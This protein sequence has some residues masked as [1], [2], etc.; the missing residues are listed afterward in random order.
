MRRI[1]TGRPSAVPRKR[2]SPRYKLLRRLCL[3]LAALAAIVG[4][5]A[6]VWNSGRMN[7]VIDAARQWSGDL[8][9]SL[10]LTI[11]EMSV[12]GRQRTS[13]SAIQTALGIRRGT[14]ILGIDLERAKERLEALPWIATAA[15]ERKLPDT[16]QVQVVERTAVGRWR[17]R[18]RILLVDRN[19]ILFAAGKAETYTHLPLLKGGGA[20]DNAAALVDML[21]SQPALAKR[22]AQ[23][24]RRGDRRW[25]LVFESG[26]LVRLPEKKPLRAWERLAYLDRQFDLLSRGL[27]VIDMR[28]PDRLVLR[29]PPGAGPAATP[30]VMAPGKNT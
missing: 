9:S 26:L 15:I 11:A 25:D 6:W 18:G 1:T 5:P 13:Q 4:A 2:G 30:A 20:T 28:L 7:P 29:T 12:S 23:A 8:A 22:V 17:R 27:V 10:H 14:P 3:R 19:G 21:A 16:I 24:V